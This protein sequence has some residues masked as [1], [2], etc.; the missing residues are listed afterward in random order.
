[1]EE[2]LTPF[3]T[4]KLKVFITTT[5]VKDFDCIKRRTSDRTKIAATGWNGS[6]Q[7]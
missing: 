6:Y 1:M 4:R 3:K 2:K 5:V 7:T